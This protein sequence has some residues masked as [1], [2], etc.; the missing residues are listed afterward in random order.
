MINLDTTTYQIL[1]VPIELAF[2]ENNQVTVSAEFDGENF[3]LT[4]YQND[5][6]KTFAPDK[7]RFSQKF[8]IYEDIQTPFCDFRLDFKD[9]Y[10]SNLA[11]K[12]YYISFRNFNAT[13]ASYQNI[14]AGSLVK[15]TSMI[16]LSMTGTNK[17]K[18]Q[19]YINTTV[20][21][22]DED[23]QNQKIQYAIRTKKYID[24]VFTDASN[25]LRTI[26]QDLGKY[27]REN[28][29]YN[30]SVEGQALFAEA[31]EL[32][33]RE[34]VIQDRLSY[35][36]NLERYI[37]TADDIGDDI[38][39]PVNVSIE[40]ANISKNIVELVELSKQKKNLEQTVTPDYP[41]LKNIND[42]IK[43]TRDVVLENLA[44]LKNATQN[45]LSNIRKR[46]ATYNTKLNTLPKKEQG[47]VRL[48]RSY[49]LTSANYEYLKQMQY[50]AG[51]A[52][53]ANV[54]DI[55]VLDQAKDVGQGPISP[56][57]RFNYL[58]AAMLSFGLPFL[59]ILV[60]EALNNKILTVEE[61]EK[62]YEIPVLGIV[63]TGK[64]DNYLAV[65]KK[66]KSSLAES[67]RALR[68]NIQF[69]FKKTEGSKTIVVT[70]SV[71]GE[72]KT[73]CSI[74][75]ASVFAMS[76][77]KTVLLGM[78]LRKPKLHEDFGVANQ[79][80]IVN[81][82]IGQK[83]VEE[84]ILQT[85]I[86]NLDII[87][88]GP[89]PP[90][91]SELILNEQMGHLMDYLKKSY[92]YIIIDTPPVGLVSDAIELFRYADAVMYVIRQNYTQK[93]MPKM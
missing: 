89:I 19:D 17:K 22:L 90:N 48:E 86:P 24:T 60:K 92:D 3:S 39:A 31:T 32:D 66:P 35:Y 65:F 93:G 33:K 18:I 85:Q 27:K 52:I 88:S 73:L 36:K 41:P 78:D 70:S 29:I 58:I 45:N 6:I 40:D 13:V 64:L 84:V 47:L 4:N 28:N 83:K 62:M 50:Q 23:Q 81:Y 1:G 14:N 69:L 76:E 26:E 10:H 43:I 12:T 34:Q 38:P 68:S 7:K 8:S 42:K 55:K 57:T 15:G 16:Q 54:S 59:F 9:G 87:I 30:L 20:R 72:G 67:F 53:A 82:L 25:S 11:G 37:R 75:M 91:P 51:T 44:N 46:L 49:G 56:N 79:A 5:S 63:G 61:I 77:K 21:V 71:S 2:G 74:S 80:G